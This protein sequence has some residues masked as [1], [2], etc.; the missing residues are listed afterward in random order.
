MLRCA[1]GVFF[2]HDGTLD[3]RLCPGCL[4]MIRDVLL[5]LRDRG[6]RAIHDPVQAFVCAM[7]SGSTIPPYPI[8]VAAPDPSVSAPHVARLEI[9][10]DA[11]HQIVDELAKA[12][13]QHL[14]P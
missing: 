3:L 10:K 14:S 4:T 9:L 7:L 6:L 12:Y 5:D 1:C 11:H 13:H 8:I 2:I